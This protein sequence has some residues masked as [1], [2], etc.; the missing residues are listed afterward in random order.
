MDASEKPILAKPPRPVMAA[1]AVGLRPSPRRRSSPRSSSSISAAIAP[2]RSAL[3]SATPIISR[4]R[5]ARSPCCSRVAMRR[6][7]RA[8]CF[9]LIALAF[10]V[11]AGLGIYHSGIEWKWWEGPATCAGGIA[12]RMGRGRLAEQL[13]NAQVIRC[14]E[15]SWRFLWLSFAGWNAVI[16]AFLAASPLGAQRRSAEPRRP[17]SESWPGS[18]RGIHVSRVLSLRRT[19]IECV[20]WMPASPV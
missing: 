15:A 2:A 6:A 14:D 18:T 1:S 3:R 10:L 5:R 13:E 4:C 9:S 16:S 17:S 11:N 20:A 12:D 7:S 19:V 8:S